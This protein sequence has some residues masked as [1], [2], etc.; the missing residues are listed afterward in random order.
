MTPT[1][2][3]PYTYRHACVGLWVAAVIAGVLVPPSGRAGASAKQTSA[4]RLRAAQRLSRPRKR[5]SKQS[6]PALLVVLDQLRTPCVA[7][8][9]TLRLRASFRRLV[10]RSPRI[11]GSS[12]CPSAR[13]KL[14]VRSPHAIRVNLVVGSWTRTASGLRLRVPH[15]PNIS[16][17]R[18]RSLPGGH[19]DQPEA[20]RRPSP[21]EDQPLLPPGRRPQIQA[22][23]RLHRAAPCHSSR[24]RTGAHCPFSRDPGFFARAVPEGAWRETLRD[25]RRRTFTSGRIRG[26]ARRTSDPAER[27][28]HPLLRSTSPR[29]GGRTT[30]RWRLAVRARC[31]TTPGKSSKASRS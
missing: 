20:D 7:S 19:L 8:S 27:W 23:I 25:P 6:A 30:R 9:G 21:A 10:W 12:N 4:V 29:A 2:A 16:L 11:L 22:S 15:S 3:V 26:S 17:G 31:V 1:H 13:W 28:S 5:S 14:I 24:P 18:S